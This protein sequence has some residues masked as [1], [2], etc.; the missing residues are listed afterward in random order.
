MVSPRSARRSR[1]RRWHGRSRYSSDLGADYRLS[2]RDTTRRSR[3]TANRGLRSTSGIIRPVAQLEFSGEPECAYSWVP[4]A[5]AT[6][7]I[8]VAVVE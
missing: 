7:A 8:V 5:V 2:G 1:G 6:S 4:L 3:W